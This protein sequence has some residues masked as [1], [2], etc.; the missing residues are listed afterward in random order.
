[1]NF[2]FIKKK[3]AI[4]LDKDCLIIGHNETE[5]TK[6]EETL[7]KMGVENGGYQDLLLNFIPFIDRRIPN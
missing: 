1:M 3:G 6:Y 4:Y 5:F 2:S 7:R